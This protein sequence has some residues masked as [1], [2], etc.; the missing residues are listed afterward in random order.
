MYVKNSKIINIYIY[1]EK[2]PLFLFFPH[3]KSMRS[4]KL[5]TIIQT[6]SAEE[7]CLQE[8]HQTQ[9]AFR[10]AGETVL[11]YIREELI[12]IFDTGA[13]LPP[14][15]PTMSPRARAIE[16]PRRDL[17]HENTMASKS[18]TSSLSILL[19]FVPKLAG[20]TLTSTYIP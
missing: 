8:T 5:Q 7:L 3:S 14:S 4:T 9:M 1:I 10:S 15:F 13:A 11:I 2:T 19:S 12:I 18:T 16:K 6:S 20:V 17:R